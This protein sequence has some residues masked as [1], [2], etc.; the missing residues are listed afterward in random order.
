MV[1]GVSFRRGL[2]ARGALV[3]AAVGALAGW[4]LGASF[5]GGSSRALAQTDYGSAHLV[6][7]GGA[8]AGEYEAPLSAE[9][10]ADAGPPQSWFAVANGTDLARLTLD[11]RGDE[12]DLL[13]FQIGDAPED[14]YQS[15]GALDGQL[16]DRGE[17]ATITVSGDLTSMNEPTPVH[18][19][20]TVEC[21]E[22]ERYGV[23]GSGDLATEVP[24][25][26]EAT[27]P[28]PPTVEPVVLG[29][30]APGSTTFA[31]T[32][33]GGPDAGTYAVWTLD[34]GCRRTGDSGWIAGYVASATRPTTLAVLALDDGAEVVGTVEA[35]FGTGP[36][37]REYR[38]LDPT[39]VIDDRGSSA[40]ITV[41]GQVEAVA[42]A[43][44]PSGSPGPSGL[45]VPS[46]SPASWAIDL[47][48]EC[49]SV[50]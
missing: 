8:Q 30:P 28:P 31:L 22:I 14:L 25:T 12:S 36:G 11:Y 24:A 35:G 41:A 39:I 17:S 32:L 4:P 46:G 20:L 50:E 29:S 1:R 42:G 19:R 6:L 47:V 43:P 27:E 7:E 49:G 9:C 21:R 3:L 2:V 16:D 5:I 48:I 15:L 34:E 10:L 38:G 44:A 26:P 18:A 37:R 23:F 40:T 13:Y 33:G 45:P